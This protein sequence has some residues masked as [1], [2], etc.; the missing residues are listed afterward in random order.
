LVVAALTTIKKIPNFFVIVSLILMPFLFFLTNSNYSWAFATQTPI[1]EEKNRASD[2]SKFILKIDGIDYS[3]LKALVWVTTGG[4]TFT[5]VIHPVSLLDPK[6]DGDGI[7]YVTMDFKKGLLKV[8][9]NFTAC[10]KVLQDDDRY[11]DHIACQEGV[12]SVN[13]KS[14]SHS[15]MGSNN[16]TTQTIDN[17]SFLVRMSL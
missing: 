4:K 12:I 6:D 1:M 3:T 13:N 17:N 2:M 5:K 10:I 14:F 16:S 7:I 8:G 9:G 11:G 15:E